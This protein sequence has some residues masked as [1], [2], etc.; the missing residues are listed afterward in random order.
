MAVQMMWER[1]LFVPAA[2][3]VIFVALVI[4]LLTA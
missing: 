1:P 4:A 2:L 3:A